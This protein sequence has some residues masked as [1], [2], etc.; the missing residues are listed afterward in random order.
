MIEAN[1]NKIKCPIF[2]AR[3]KFIQELNHDIWREDLTAGEL[4]NKAHSLLTE[5]DILSECPKYKQEISRCR[6][7]KAINDLRKSRVVYLTGQTANLS[8][9]TKEKVLC[10]YSQK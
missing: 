1:K 6:M 10:F 5:L 9:F 2:S 3:E 7:C 8:L 4:T